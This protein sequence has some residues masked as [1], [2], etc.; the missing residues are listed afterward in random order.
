MK[1]G[2]GAKGLISILRESFATFGIPDELASDGGPE[3]TSTVTTQFLQDWGVHHRLS[4]VAFPH[5]NCRAEV[6]VKTIKRLISGNVDGHGDLNSDKFQRAL[7]QYRN[8]HKVMPSQQHLRQEDQGPP[9]RDSRNVQP[10]HRLE[11]VTRMQGE[12]TSQPTRHIGREI[13]SEHTKALPP[14]TVGTPVRIQNQTGKQWDRTGI[15][16]EARPFDQYNV[17]VDGAGR[18]T[19]R[20]R[21]FLRSYVPV[22][23][24]NLLRRTAL[25]DAHSQPLTPPLPGEQRTTDPSRSGRETPRLTGPGT[26]PRT[27]T[28]DPESRT[29]TTTPPPRRSTRVKKKPAWSL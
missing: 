27:Y 7:L 2:D 8:T 28:S 17:K 12:S 3:F 26:P 4:S 25:E 19:L 24:P 1:A 13:W 9:T 15:V 23:P 29:P 6:A 21:R 20:N 16:V 18:V 11:G 14:L 10:P 22:C 5:S